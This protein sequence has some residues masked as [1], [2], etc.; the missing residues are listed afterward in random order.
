[1]HRSTHILH[2]TDWLERFEGLLTYLT[3]NWNSLLV[4]M[5]DVNID[6]ATQQSHQSVP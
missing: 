4:L 5:G 6:T 3:V 1:M 2:N